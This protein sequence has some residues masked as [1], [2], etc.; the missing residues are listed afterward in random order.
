MNGGDS[1]S[2]DSS[3]AKS[4]A[5]AS[6]ILIVALL[7]VGSASSGILRHL[8]QTA[9]SWVAVYLGFQRRPTA[10]LAALPTFLFWL[11]IVSM[12]WLFLLGYPSPVR[13][14][15]SPIEIAMTVIVGIAS[16]FGIARSVGS[17][18]LA[19]YGKGPAGLANYGFNAR[20]GLPWYSAGAIFLGV[21]ALQLLAFRIS[22]IPGISNH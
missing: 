22:L 14:H 11:S 10:K 6:L 1:P 21:L 9:P 2:N 12:I 20:S 15:F 8:V 4:I 18:G 13:G 5:I 7:I 19:I 17:A 3:V 16:V